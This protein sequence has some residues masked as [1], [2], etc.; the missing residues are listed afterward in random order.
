M[1]DET[2]LEAEEKMEKAVSF[3]KEDLSSVRTGRANPGMFARIVVEAYGSTMPLNQV[4][5]VNIPEAR[6]VIVKPYDQSQLGAIEK[7]IRESDLGVNPTNDGQIIRITIPQL[8]EERRKEMV[9]MVK[10]KGED[11]K[12][13]IRGVRRKSKEELDRIAKDG[14]AGEDEVARAEKELQ[15]LTDN[16]VAKVDEL[17]KHKEAELLEV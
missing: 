13:H 4:A 17:V 14:E 8:T 10:A 5:G 6:M 12:V 3:A 11:A 9:K 15:H 2:L 1:I 7:A 16:Y